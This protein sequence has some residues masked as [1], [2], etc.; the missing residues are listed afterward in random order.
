MSLRSGA[1][2]VVYA[3][4]LGDEF[5]DIAGHDNL[6]HETREVEPADFEGCVIAYGALENFEGDQ[7]VYE[8]AKAAGA[9]VNVADTTPLCDFITPAIL[10]RAPVVVGISSGGTSPLLVRWVKA[11]LETLVPSSLGRLADF[12]GRQRDKVATRLPE[13]PERRYFW[14]RVVDGSV[15]DRYMAGDEAGAAADFDSELDKAS[16]AAGGTRLGEVYLVGAG[17]GDPDLLTF[18]ALRLMQRADVVLYDRLIGRGILNLVRRDAE[19]IYVG[20]MPKDHTLPQ[21]EISALLARLAREGKRVLRLK[22]GDPFIFGRG[23]EELEA[24]AEQ[25]IPFQVVPGITAASGCS[26]C[27][28]HTT[29]APGPCAYVCLRDRTYQGRRHR[30]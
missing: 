5:L 24:L 3:E 29:H 30:S 19:R 26:V 8:M 21:E 25:G 18:R 7:R 6:V 17:P 11:R 28:R 15:A 27:A 2:V 16:S 10:D 12:L 13:G 4:Q 9:L 22:G 20:K 23:G 14:E 1:R